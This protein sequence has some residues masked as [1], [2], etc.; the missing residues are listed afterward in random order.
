[1]EKIFSCS[2]YAG[3]PGEAARRRT[4]RLSWRRTRQRNIERLVDLQAGVMKMEPVHIP[5]RTFQVGLDMQ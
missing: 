5:Q 4:K 3:R 2:L 1:M